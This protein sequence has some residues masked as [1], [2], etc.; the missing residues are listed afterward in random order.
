MAFGVQMSAESREHTRRALLDAAVEQ[1]ARYGY[2]ATSH[3][4][5]AAEAGIGRTTFYEYFASKE[6][7]LVDLVATRVPELMAELVAGIPDGLPPEQELGELTARMVEFVGT[8]HLGLLLHQE[9]PRLSDAAQGRIAQS[10]VNLSTAFADIYLRG[11]DTGVFRAMPHRLAVRLMYEVIMTA[12][13]E[14]MD[15]DDPKQHVH[16]MAEATVEFLLSGLRH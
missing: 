14:V 10:H 12:G 6:E 5:I 1:F 9:V 8:D 3:A 7:L 15:A 16:T 11:L 4:D 2:M 13:R